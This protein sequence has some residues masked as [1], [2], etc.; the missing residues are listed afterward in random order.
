MKHR[1]VITTVQT[2]LEVLKDYLGENYLPQDTKVVKFRANTS[3]K[4]RFELLCESEGWTGL[5]EP[6]Q[7]KI[8]LSRTFAVGGR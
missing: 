4:G 7:V 2:I 8:H 3:E 6:L 1:M 5:E